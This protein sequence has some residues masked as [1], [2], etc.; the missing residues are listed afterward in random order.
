M[1]GRT[2]PLR[3]A[4]PPASTVELP[5]VASQMR[6]LGLLL[7]LVVVV[8]VVAIII[9]PKLHNPG[10]LANGTA[11]PSFTLSADDG[12]QHTLPAAAPGGATVVLF[13]EATC[14]HCQEEAPK[15]C[16][17][18]RQHPHTTFV[19]VGAAEE[20]SDA[21]RAFRGAHMA[22]CGASLFPLLVDSSADVTHRYVVA[23]VPTIYVIDASGKVAYSGTGTDGVDAATPVIDRLERG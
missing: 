6:K 23:V 19:G 10:L 8:T 17:L 4:P 5:S 9:T 7:L 12:N 21:L 16:D 15:V 11:A 18:A 14:P 20:N 13:I 22:Q 3:P 1:S 2:P